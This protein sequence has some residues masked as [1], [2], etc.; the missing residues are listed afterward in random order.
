MCQGDLDLMSIPLVASLSRY[1]EHA[2]ANVDK[3][4]LNDFLV[5]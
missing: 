4:G 2:A 3:I 1:A 5:Y